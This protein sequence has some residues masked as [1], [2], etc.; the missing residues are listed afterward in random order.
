MALKSSEEFLRTALTNSTFDIDALDKALRKSLDTSF[1][2]LY[3]LQR[4]T[5]IYEEYFYTT[6][7][8]EDQPD[9]GDLYL[10]KIERVCVNIPVELILTNAREAYRKSYLYNTEIPIDTIEHNHVIFGKLPV[11]MLD[12]RVLKDFYVRIYDGYFTVI[13]PFR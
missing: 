1:S 5:V 7:N 2:Y 13:T 3:R 8:V 10:D 6:Q 4:N 12:N 11:I 9:Y